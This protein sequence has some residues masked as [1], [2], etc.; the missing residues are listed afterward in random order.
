MPKTW[1]LDFKEKKFL[2]VPE[3]MRLFIRKKLLIREKVRFITHFNIK[4]YSKINWRNICKTF[5]LLFSRE[6]KPIG[7][8]EKECVLRKVKWSEVAQSC[9]TLCNPMDCS[10]PGSPI[11]GILQARTLEWV[12]IS[13]SR[14]SS[15]PRDWTQ[16]SH[17]AGRL[18]NLRATREAHFKERL[19]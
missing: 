5:V 9:P 14:G 16:V 10:P 19:L 1:V 15:W 6:T 3:K 13:F 4:L 2:W 8:R 17:V 11:H 7:F 18:F 12:A